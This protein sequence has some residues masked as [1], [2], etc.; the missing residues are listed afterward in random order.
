MSRTT[1]VSISALAAAAGLITTI[2]REG[3]PEQEISPGADHVHHLQP[4]QSLTIRAAERFEQPA[5]ARVSIEDPTGALA[6]AAG[7]QTLE[8]GLKQDHGSNPPADPP[9]ASGAGTS[10]TDNGATTSRTTRTKS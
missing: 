4:G 3:Y 2:R 1:A 6:A 7:G 8:E 9:L 5:E 10:V